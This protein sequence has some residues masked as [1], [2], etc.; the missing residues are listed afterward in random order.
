MRGGPLR[1]AEPNG[2]LLMQHIYLSE[3]SVYP[4]ES[5][6]YHEIPVHLVPFSHQ[7]FI[8]L[9]MNRCGLSRCRTCTLVQLCTSSDTDGIV[10]VYEWLA[11]NSMI[12]ITIL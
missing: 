10:F 5:N 3:S 12:A 4:R 9:C 8:G 6:V 2:N 7:L 1:Y 11:I